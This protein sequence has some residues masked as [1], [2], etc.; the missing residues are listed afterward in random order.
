[1]MMKTPITAAAAAACK[2][3]TRSTAPCVFGRSIFESLRTD[4]F[5]GSETFQAGL[6][7]SYHCDRMLVDLEET[8]DGSVVLTPS[9]GDS[10]SGTAATTTTANNT[11]LHHRIPLG[12]ARDCPTLT[13]RAAEDDRFDRRCRPYV[14]LAVVGMVTDNHPSTSGGG[15][16]FTLLITRRPSYMRSFPGAFVFPGGGVEPED[17]S[18]EQALSREVWEETGLIVSEDSWKLECLWESIYPTQLSAL[19]NDSSATDGAIRAHHLVCYFSGTPE[20]TPTS[21][22]TLC[23][24]EVDGAVWMSRNNTRDLLEATARIEKDVNR[25]VP[26]MLRGQI[27]ALHATASSNRNSNQESILLSDLAGIYPRLEKEDERFCG[28]AQGSLFALEEFIWN[29]PTS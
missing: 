3:W 26:E 12:R 11:A 7:P 20:T 27:I 10:E 23:E 21:S 6:V 24:E 13:Q 2:V 5:D 19:V 16:T 17:A 18:L 22:L 15:D 1:M 9:L 4:N 25:V 14:S 28:M 29:Q 8:E